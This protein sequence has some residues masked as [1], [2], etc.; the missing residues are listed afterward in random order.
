MKGLKHCFNI[1]SVADH[2]TIIHYLLLFQFVFLVLLSSGLLPVASPSSH[3][4]HKTFERRTESLSNV[5]N[6]F[7]FQLNE[8]FHLYYRKLPKSISFATFFVV[9]CILSENRDWYNSLLLYIHLAI[10]SSLTHPHTHTHPFII[11]LL[12]RPFVFTITTIN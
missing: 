10:S 8:S 11:Y 2:L 12:L 4:I 6:M 5:Q 1:I 9:F 7:L 3:L